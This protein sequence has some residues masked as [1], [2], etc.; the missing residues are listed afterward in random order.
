MLLNTKNGI[1]AVSYNLLLIKIIDALNWPQI[2]FI[3]ENNSPQ[4]KELK[5]MHVLKYFN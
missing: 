3:E 1:I 2:I 5:E 4:L